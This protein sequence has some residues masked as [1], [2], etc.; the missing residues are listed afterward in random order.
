MIFNNLS[1]KYI[2]KF[3]SD[4]F[5][6]EIKDC[7]TSTNSIM[8]EKAL[9]GEKEFSVLIAKTQ[10]AG[11]GRMG[12]SF[13]SPKGTGLYMSVVLKPKNGIN[14]LL[15]TTDAAV[16]AAF[17][18]EKLLGKEVGIKWVNDIYL[19]EKKVCGILA[20]MV[21]DSVVLGIGINILEP[22]N[23]FP[24]DI[25]N[26]AGALFEKN[27]PRL[28][29]KVAIEFLNTFLKIYINPDRAFLLNEYRKRSV[30]TGK[31]IFIL[32]DGG[33]ESAKAVG[34]GDDYSLIVEKANGE[35]VPVY[36]GDVSIKYQTE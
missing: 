5:E 21:E 6:I 34:I 26:R 23:G 35:T 18:F 14:P 20:E 1:E 17:A 24:D 13:H 30:I 10:T 15:I 3:L 28:R 19:N 7:V 36:T 4:A 25:K 31:E 32:K 8:K 12:R 33:E 11:R 16:S 9:N 29:E 2:K 22:K 27:K